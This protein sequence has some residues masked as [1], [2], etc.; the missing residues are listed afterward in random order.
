MA[1]KSGNAATK[2][3]SNG[4]K[5]KKRLILNAFVETC[6]SSWSWG[7]VQVDILTL[8]KALDI[9][10]QVGYLQLVSTYQRKG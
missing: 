8:E 6:E 2:G 1:L 3:T 4:V 10:V 5:F 9:K 7:P